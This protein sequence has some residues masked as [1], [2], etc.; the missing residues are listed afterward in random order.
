MRRRGGKFSDAATRRGG[1]GGRPGRPTGNS[2]G[3]TPSPLYTILP[4][5][6]KFL[7]Q[8]GAAD[9]LHHVGPAAPQDFPARSRV[10]LAPQIPA[11][12]RHGP[13]ELSWG[14]GRRRDLGQTS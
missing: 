7:V 2:P 6:E 9:H 8:L 3:L 1:G 12:F 10:V 5:V 14:Q 11:A 4:A 13:V